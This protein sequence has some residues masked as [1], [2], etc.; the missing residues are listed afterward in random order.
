MKMKEERSGCHID[1]ERKCMP[2][3]NLDQSRPCRAEF[4]CEAPRAS[5]VYLIGTFNDGDTRATPM[6]RDESGDWTAVLELLPGEYQY[7]YVIVYRC[8]MNVPDEDHC[9]TISH[10]SADFREKQ[11]IGA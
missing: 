2:R 3:P 1:S 8:E 10:M 5:E 11:R 7:K 9:G 4:T 6:T